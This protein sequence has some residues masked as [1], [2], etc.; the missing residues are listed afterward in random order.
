M[1]FTD[2]VGEIIDPR[3]TGGEARGEGV[4]MGAAEHVG[5]ANNAW[6]NSNSRDS[7]VEFCVGGGEKEFFQQSSIPRKERWFERP[8]GSGMH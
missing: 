6:S 5:L 7:R 8:S 3:R 1:V 4:E 2:I